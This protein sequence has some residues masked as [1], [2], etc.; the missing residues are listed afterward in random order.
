M[1]RRT[2]ST[3][4]FDLGGVL[5]ECSIVDDLNAMLGTSLPDDVLTARWL[6]SPTVRAFELGQTSPHDFATAFLDEWQIALT[7]E[8]FVTAFTA[9]ARGPLAGAEA[10][11]ERLRENHTVCC[12]SNSN[13]LHWARVGPFLGCFDAAF[14]SH[15]LAEIKPDEAVFVQVMAQ[16]DVDADSLWFFDDSRPNVEAAE[17]L[18]IKSFLVD[19][20]PAVERALTAEGLIG[21]R[22]V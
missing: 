13:A 20:V 3:L 11:L 19:G 16:L 10:L 1:A 14:S 6:G 18:G 17:R 2:P 15:L 12:L 21:G 8:Q 7:P 9:S 22:H 4:L 5:F